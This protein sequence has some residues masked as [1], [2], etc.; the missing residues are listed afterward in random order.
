V[1]SR[2]DKEGP[3][4]RKK[5]NKRKING[6]LVLDKPVGVTSNAALQMTKRLFE[7]AKAGHTGSLDPLATGVLPLCFG[8]ATKFSQYLLDADKRYLAT[9]KLGV[10]T[11]TGDAEGEIVA[12]VQVPS[13]ELSEIDAVLDQFRGKI[14]QTPSMFSALKVNGQPLYKLARQGIEVE[15]KSREVTILRYDALEYEGDLLKVDIECTKGTYVR[16]LAE[17][18]GKALGCGAHVAELRRIKSG[19]YELAESVTVAELEK[20]KEEEGLAL[21]D[22]LLLPVESS[23]ED[24]PA[25]N[26]TE[27][28]A[29]YFKQGQAVQVAKAPGSGWVRIFSEVESNE[30]VF[31]GVG[32]ILEDGKVA[33]RRL[34]V[35]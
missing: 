16:S 5:V 35:S 21:L 29:A 22:A 14:Q 26:L 33:P 7:A 10:S 6:V 3:V 32:E 31:M 27:L 23:I 1:S 17:D 24:W 20:I 11:T 4:V 19:P 8:E 25:I 9:F 34:V 28:T 12:K 2:N 18:L 15:R 30:P 13:L